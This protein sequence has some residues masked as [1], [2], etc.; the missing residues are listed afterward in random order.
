MYTIISEMN[1]NNT[2]NYGSTLGNI[3]YLYL[4]SARYRVNVVCIGKFEC[5]FIIMDLNNNYAYIQVAQTIA[6]STTEQCEYRPFSYIRDGYP[7]IF[8]DYGQ[9]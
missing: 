6:D 9:V 8:S 7:K 4:V 1:T 5:D 3:V 2:I